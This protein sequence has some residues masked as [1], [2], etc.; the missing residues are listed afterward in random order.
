MDLKEFYLQNIK[1]TEYHYRF[2]D[3]ILHANDVY[4]IFSG[5]E[6]VSDYCYEIYDSEEAITKFKELCLPE[7]SFADNTNKCWFF[8]LSYYLYKMGYEIKE[9]PRILAR[10]PE[11]PSTFTYNDIRSRLIAEGKDTNGIVKYAT[12]RA[13]VANLTFERKSAHIEIDQSIDHK[14]IEIST[15]QASFINMSIDE[16]LAE[17]ANLIENLLKKDGKFASVDYDSACYGFITD[18]SVRKYRTKLHC[19]RHS[20]D[21]SLKER[22]LYSE[23]QKNF[24]VDYGLTI[25][26]VV[27]ALTH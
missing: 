26:K 8:L 9:Y 5:Y 22:S 25:I 11:E 12:R 6:E 18:D 13:Y 27:Y 4:N 10:P 3:S 24:L 21:E 20:A 1:E 19:F 7:V 2:R 23:I 15:R 14:F 17:I 16:K